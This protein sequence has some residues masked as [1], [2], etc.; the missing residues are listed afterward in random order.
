MSLPNA[1]CSPRSACSIQPI[2]SACCSMLRHRPTLYTHNTC[3]G[4]TDL[5]LSEDRGS[6]I[7]DRAVSILHPRSSILDLLHFG[8]RNYDTSCTI[9]AARRGAS[10]C[11]GIPTTTS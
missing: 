10:I 6:R 1:A 4:F 11:N 3:E 8:L 9:Q 7:E 5:Q 2:S